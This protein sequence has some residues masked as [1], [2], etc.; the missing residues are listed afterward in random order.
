LLL[1]S[2]K[3]AYFL[4][5][6]GQTTQEKRQVF[7]DD[8]CVDTKRFEEAV[9]LILE[10]ADNMEKSSLI[11]KIFKACILGKILLTDC[12]RLSDMVNRAFWGDLEKLLHGVELPENCQQRLFM[13]G[14]YRLK[15]QPLH[16]DSSA[17]FKYEGNEYAMAL[18]LIHKEKF[19]ELRGNVRT[20]LLKKEGQN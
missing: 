3:I 15:G 11:G 10:Q 16:L 7:V 1:Q 14:L 20:V 4:A 8:N 12:T 13:A 9:L 2:Q 5:Q 6:V 18:A 19:N 17:E